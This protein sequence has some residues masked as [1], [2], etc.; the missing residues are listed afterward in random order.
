[1]E[2]VVNAGQ[3]RVDLTEAT[4]TRL[5]THI[6]AAKVSL[7]LP[8]AQDLSADLSV[9]AGALSICVPSDLGLRIRSDGVL[10]G[11]DFAGL[12]LDGNVWE[13]PGYSMANHHAD[14]SVTV[15]VG[16]VDINPLG[17]CK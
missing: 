3:A 4:L 14:V 13:S 1:V 12:V 11:T 2:L 5:S 16:S 15:N 6:N 10:G 9:N 7:L 17:G 8:A